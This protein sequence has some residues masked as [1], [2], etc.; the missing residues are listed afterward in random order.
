MFKQL[1][2]KIIFCILVLSPDFG[3][4]ASSS[5]DDVRKIFLNSLAGYSAITSA[6][7]L[8][9]FIES[10]QRGASKDVSVLAYIID[11]S[12]NVT[13]VA[14]I[15][16]SG[17]S[18]AS[19]LPP[20]VAIAADLAVI[21]QSLYYNYLRSWLFKDRHYHSVDDI[22]VIL[23][24]SRNNVCYINKKSYSIKHHNFF[25]DRGWFGPKFIK[26]DEKRHLNE[27]DQA[28]EM[29][30]FVD[31]LS[32]LLFLKGF[33]IKDNIIIKRK[34]LIISIIT[35]SLLEYTIYLYSYN[36]IIIKKDENNDELVVNDDSCI[37]EFNDD[38][39]R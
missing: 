11:A 22:Q 37:I 5:D 21:L 16:L 6:A 1:L 10:A 12:G 8:A 30:D 28:W 14:Q 24:S 39:H 25:I 36:P 31:Y 18:L 15:L 2:Y 32:S 17:G 4:S 29:T 34:A 13:L 23:K 35:N 26:M 20:T 38:T 33:T 7:P 19:A 27:H 3:F 9:Q